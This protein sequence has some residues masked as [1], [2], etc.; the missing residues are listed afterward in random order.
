[1]R[2]N[3]NRSINKSQ[4]IKTLF[5]SNEGINVGKVHREIFKVDL[6]LNYLFDGFKDKTF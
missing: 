1:M 5:F 6:T 2:H 3:T 4:N